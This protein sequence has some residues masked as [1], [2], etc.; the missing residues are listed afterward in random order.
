MDGGADGAQDSALACLQSSVP[1]KS[2]LPY[3]AQT[4]TFCY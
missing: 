3:L 4:K 2:S 1:L